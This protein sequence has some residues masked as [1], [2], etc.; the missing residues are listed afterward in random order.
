MLELLTLGGIVTGFA[1]WEFWI[2]TLVVFGVFIALT[3]G[4]HW[5]WATTLFVGVFASLWMFGIFNIWNYAVR[6]PASG[7]TGILVW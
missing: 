5:G 1:I 7:I 4:E 2:V 6:H 3:E